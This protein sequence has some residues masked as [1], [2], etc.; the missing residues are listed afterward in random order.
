MTHASIV[1]FVGGGQMG[2]GLAHNLL[3]TDSPS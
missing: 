1:G 2:L 3:A